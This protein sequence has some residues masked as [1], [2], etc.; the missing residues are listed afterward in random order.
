MKFV[1]HQIN[2]DLCSAQHV[3]NNS[4]LV[5]ALELQTVELIQRLSRDAVVTNQY[6][7][8]LF[9]YFIEPIPLIAFLNR[10]KTFV[11]E[12]MIMPINLK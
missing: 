7:C 8:Q 9:L 11:I 5:E 4:S 3:I 6:D 12:R 1:L 2:L 10:L